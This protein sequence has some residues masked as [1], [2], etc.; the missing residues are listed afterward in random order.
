MSLENLPWQYGPRNPLK[1]KRQMRRISKKRARL[2]RQYLKHRD[3]YLKAH[4]I[5]EKCKLVRASDIHHRKGK[6]GKLL[7]AAEWFLSVCRD[8]HQWIHNNPE[9]SY[10]LGLSIK[11]Y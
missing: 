9:D 8:C 7:C 1:R 5:C 4:P 11:R 6:L 3:E 2:N 10:E